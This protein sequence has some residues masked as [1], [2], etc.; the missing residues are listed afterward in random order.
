MRSII[1]TAAI[2]ALCAA[3][4]AQSD[5]AA[6]AFDT[7]DIHASPRGV[8]EGGIY[9]HANRL[10][11]HGY[12]MLHLITT[13][14]GVKESQIFGGP[15]WLDTSRFEIIAKSQRPVTTVTFQPMLQALLAER[16]QLKVLTEDK[17]EQVFALVPTK[18][19]LL[20][21]SAAAGDPGCK[22]TNEEGYL[23]LTCHNVTMGYL[24]DLLP[25]A[26]PNYF[27]HPVLD[28]TGLA[29]SYDVT[30][31]WTGR[32]QIGGGDA[33]HPSISLFAYIEKQLGIKVEPQTRPASSLVIEKVNE[34]PAPNP[35]GTLEKL[36]P[37]VTEFE[38]AEV[39]PSKPDTKFDYMMKNG[40]LEAFGVT[41]KDLISFAY[42][43]DD[44]MLPGG[45]KWLET[46]RFDIIAKTDPTVTDGT[47]EAMLRTLLAE[48][49]HL[50][51]HFAEQPVSV[52]ALTAPKV[53][54]KLAE[55]S[56]EEHA[57]CK[58][59]PKD[60]AFTYS[61]RNTTMAQL[62]DKLPSVGGAAGYLNQHPMV[63]LTG[64]KG[65]Y[66]FDIVWSPPARVYGRGGRGDSGASP[67]GAMPTASAPS[68]GL[69]IFE[70]LEKQLGLKLSVEKHPMPVV[71]IDHVDRTP[72]DN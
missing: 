22:R 52:W 68:G 18:R 55:T 56:G 31:K 41:M 4:Y 72:S 70:A 17:P 30:L 14:Y 27:D 35:P 65:S 23:T 24:A 5:A 61:C 71:V 45:E 20:K 8:R 40:R 2:L 1:S 46:D 69:T 25:G 57:G 34:A 50:K 48:R 63:D 10:E 15:N 59:T 60:G 64:L 28:K 11:L 37:P 26:A 16:F 38:V 29:G 43:L 47:L 42:D 33:D 32:G 67:P 54:G 51:S 62:A 36:P 7:A 3:A 9:L 21:E 12:T 19:V 13:A 39:R 49:F 53:K 58:R 6:P 66:D 44:Y